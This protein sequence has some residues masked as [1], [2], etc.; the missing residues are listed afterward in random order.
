MYEGQVT[1]ISINALP[2]Y[3]K[4]DIIRQ[5]AGK[6]PLSD[7][8]IQDVLNARKNDEDRDAFEIGVEAFNLIRPD[9]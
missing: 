1:K 8:F 5:L 6:I 2:T 9:E 7:P 4:S 3:K